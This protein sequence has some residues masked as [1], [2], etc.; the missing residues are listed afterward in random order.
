MLYFHTWKH[1]DSQFGLK[2]AINFQIVLEG[3]IGGIQNQIWNKAGENGWTDW[4]ICSLFYSYHHL[5]FL[6][7]M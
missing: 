7:G 6:L 3:W 5:S 4:W 2:Y 1:G